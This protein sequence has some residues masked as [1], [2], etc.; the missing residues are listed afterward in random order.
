MTKIDEKSFI[1]GFNAGYL[2]EEYEPLTLNKVLKNIHPTNPFVSG[3]ILGQKEYQV[4]RSINE[5]AL[6]RKSKDRNIDFR[7]L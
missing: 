2:L 1:T 3:L 4:Y 7:E 5:L 6:L